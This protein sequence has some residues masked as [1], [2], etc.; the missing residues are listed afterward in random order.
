[1]ENQ[2]KQK[3]QKKKKQ[4]KK[5][6]L[7]PGRRGEIIKSVETKYF[8]VLSLGNAIGSG[9]T[10]FL[11]DNI[12]QGVSQSHRIGDFVSIRKI[13]LN[14]SIYTVN[15]DIVTTIRLVLFRWVPDNSLHTVVVGDI[16]ESPASANTLSHYNFQ[17]QDNYEVLWEKQFQQS[18]IP[19]APTD[20]SNV[21]ATGLIIPV[22]K[23]PDQEFQL[24]SNSGSNQLYFLAISDS[25]L[26]PF[27]ILNF[28]FRFYFEDSIRAHPHRM[29]K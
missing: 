9:A 12:P 26:T 18:G 24:G 11:V 14:Y 19:T 16:L 23:H 13:I 25:A 3:T 8:D 15:S 21:G 10:T 22:G 6:G 5:R 28:S 27:P 7:R 17:L 4:Q 1:M 29:V 2:A 20:R